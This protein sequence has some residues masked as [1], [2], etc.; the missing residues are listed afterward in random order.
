[1]TTKPNPMDVWC[2]VR[3]EGRPSRFRARIASGSERSIFRESHN[4][5]ILGYETRIKLVL[6]DGEK[7]TAYEVP[8]IVTLAGRSAAVALAVVQDPIPRNLLGND[9]L[10]ALGPRINCAT[11]EITFKDKP[12]KE[13][14]VGGGLWTFGEAKK[15]R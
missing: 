10:C 9:L 14:L 7:L 6:P 11:G 4:L 15:P 8:A 2:S 1:M 12:R 5:R 13:F 3:T